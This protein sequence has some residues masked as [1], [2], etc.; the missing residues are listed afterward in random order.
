MQFR[1]WAGL[2]LLEDVTAREIIM[3]YDPGRSRSML[4]NVGLPSPTFN[5]S[6]CSGGPALTFEVKENLIEI[7]ASGVITDGPNDGSSGAFGEIAVLH[8]ARLDCMNAD[9]MISD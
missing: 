2:E 5:L 3:A 7:Y 9:G 6:G 1:A 4:N 8:A